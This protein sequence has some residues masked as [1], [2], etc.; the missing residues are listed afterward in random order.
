VKKVHALCTQH[1]WV[2]PTVYQGNYNPVSRHIERDL[3]P[4]LRA[5]NIA[6]YA[7]SP[8]AGGFLVKDPSIFSDNEG[9]KSSARWA[10]GSPLGSLYRTLYGKPALIAA[11]KDWEAIAAEYGIGKSALAYRWVVYHSALKGEYGDGCIIGASTPAQL[12]QTVGD[13]DA[14]PLP[15]GA[16]KRIEEV[17]ERVK[18]EAPVD[19]YQSATPKLA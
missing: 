12:I 6:F 11:L 3:F 19:N 7:Y 13:L 1:S 9:V 10:K 17:W 4:V 5:L 8:L 18:D 15:E 2:P 14:G 16:V